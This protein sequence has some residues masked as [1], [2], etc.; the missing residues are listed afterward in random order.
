MEKLYYAILQKQIYT[1]KCINE[2]GEIEHDYGEFVGLKD[3]YSAF[4][5]FALCS[6]IINSNTKGEFVVEPPFPENVEEIFSPKS[7]SLR[8]DTKN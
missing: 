3:A 4:N 2:Q 8:F 7:R 1:I 6:A 5:Y